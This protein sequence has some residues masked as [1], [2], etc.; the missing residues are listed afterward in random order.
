MGIPMVTRVKLVLTTKIKSNEK[1]HNESVR[2][3][4]I[5]WDSGNNYY[6]NCKFDNNDNV[7]IQS[8]GEMVDAI[9]REV[10]L[11]KPHHAGE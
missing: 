6:I 7:K 3:K 1:I 9:L 4:A 2:N 10:E 11:Y 8:G 5:W